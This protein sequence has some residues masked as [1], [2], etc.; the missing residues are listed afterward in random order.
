MASV[1]KRREVTVATIHRT[2]LR[3]VLLPITLIAAAPAGDQRATLEALRRI[4]L[5]L[6]TI[7]YRLTTANATLCR[8]LSPT[9]GW[10]LHALGQYDAG[11]RD[12]ARAVFGFETPIAVEAV[13]AGAP[14]ARA[15]V[16][17]RDSIVAVDGVDV[18]TDVPGG[19]ASSAARDRMTGRI[20]A[21]PAARPLRVELVRDGVRRTVTIPAA[22]GCRSGFEV[23]LGPK[24]T[25]VADG[26]IVQ[27]GVR[28]FERYGDDAVAV[29]VAHELAHN[30]LHHRE[31]LDA[32]K[33]GRGLFADV[34]RNGRLFRRTEDDADLLGLYLIRNA[35][36][37]PQ[38]AV[39]FWRDHGGDVDGGL[40]RSRTHGSSKARAAALEAEIAH[41]PRDAP[42]PYR[43]PVLATRDQPLQ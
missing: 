5:R 24:M 4:D 3:G 10:A 42:V 28:F 36:Y 12:D 7:A 14:A 16:R 32:A 41:I 11:L 15:G 8:E 26:S 29:V 19:P 6:A 38:N 40:L 33:V 35:G 2:G 17:D 18:P 30:I 20:A 27:I 43:P 1:P 34:G 22:A 37:D 31:R 13:V 21:L 39:R 9:P 23:L 25:A